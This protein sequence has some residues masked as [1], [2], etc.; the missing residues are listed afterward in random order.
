MLLWRVDLTASRLW[1]LSAGPYLLSL[2]LW[3]YKLGSVIN[4]ICFSSD[5]CHW[6]I[7]KILN[8][9]IITVN[10]SGWSS[11]NKQQ[12]SCSVSFC[13]LWV[14]VSQVCLNMFGSVSARHLWQERFLPSWYLV[15]SDWN[16]LRLVE[17][18]NFPKSRYQCTLAGL[19]LALFKTRRCFP[20][21]YKHLKTSESP[22]NWAEQGYGCK[23]RLVCAAA[24]GANGWSLCHSSSVMNG[25]KGESRAKD[26]DT[27]W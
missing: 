10:V 4:I 3:A 20:G 24:S 7:I 26:T 15:Y 21:G 2:S 13:L 27:Q 8:Y 11:P 22:T 17:I 23:H 9:T 5:I 19:F 1:L 6:N 14:L 25:M 18:W 16:N 12:Q